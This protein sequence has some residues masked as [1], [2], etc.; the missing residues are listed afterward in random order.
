[1]LL[2][3]KNRDVIKNAF[4]VSEAL[5]A[6]ID[7]LVLTADSRARLGIPVPGDSRHARF[8]WQYQAG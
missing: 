4:F 2:T 6:T 3:G 1:M 8:K 5:F 7:I